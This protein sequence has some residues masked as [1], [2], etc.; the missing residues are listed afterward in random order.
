MK[1]LLLIIIAF[2]SGLTNNQSFGQR[3][4]IYDLEQ[5][6][7]KGDKSAL[8]DIAK[9]FDSKNEVTEFLGYH[10]I[11]TNESLVAKRIVEENCIFTDSEITIAG[12]TTSNDFLSFLNAYKDKITFSKLADAFLITPLELRNSKAEFRQISDAKKSELQSKYKN[13]LTKEWVKKAKIDSLIHE[14]D[15]KALLTIASELFKI[16][17][18]FDNYHSNEEE[19]TQLL[20]ILMGNEIAVEN[21]KNELTWHI[22]KAFYREASLNLLIYFANNYYKFKW[23]ELSSSFSNV[24]I[25][26]NAIGKEGSLFELLNSRND[27]IAVDAFVQLTRC[28]PESVDHFADEY[29]EADIDKSSAI[30]IFPYRFLKQLSVLTSYCREN[31]IDFV[32][33]HALQLTIRKLD[34]DLPFTERRR[35]EDSV[36]YNLPIDEITAFEYWAAINEQSWGITYSAGRILDIF[37]SK[38]WNEILKT[39]KCLQLFLKKS[40]LFD[41]LGII[42]I[43]NDYLKKF[44]NNGEVGIKNLESIHSEDQEIQAQIE[45]AKLFCAQP[46]KVPNDTMKVNDG[47]RDYNISNVTEKIKRIKKIRNQEKLEDELVELLSQINYSQIGEALREIENIVFK[48]MSWEKYTFME[49]DWGFFVDNNFDTL[50]TRTAFLKLYDKLSEYEL[51]SYFLDKAD[52]DYRNRDN[53]LNYDK[54][55]DIL[56]YNVVVAFVGGGGSKQ[57]NEVYAIVKILELT[58]KTTLGYPKKLCNSSGIYGCDSQDRANEWMQFIRNNKLLKES[59]SELV[60]FHYE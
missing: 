16:R 22:D 17:Y 28:N 6:L 15:S 58:H 14:K 59:H 32:G 55:F 11:H 1:T 45:K 46:L 39:E 18:R 48:D 25:Q 10:I 41:Q 42:G 12:N 57:D 49:R 21:E 34:S 54:I 31:S 56:K 4:P 38:H 35:L 43:C 19:Y 47:N 33:S 13:L 52:I 20:H 29:Q 24:E 50:P 36:I 53:S 26:V 23:N 3:H 8:F 44:I 37:Y 60:S 51:Y 30:P 2:I 9:Y 5:K 27:S 7:M 40:Y